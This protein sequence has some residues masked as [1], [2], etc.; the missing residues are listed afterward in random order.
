MEFQD[1][2]RVDRP[3]ASNLGEPCSNP[4]GSLPDFRM[5]E[6]CQTVLLA[7]AFSRGSPISPALHA[8]T[9]PYSPHFASI[10]SQDLNVKNRSNLSTTLNLYEPWRY[11]TLYEV[12]EELSV[13]GDDFTRRICHLYITFEEFLEQ[14]K[15][16]GRPDIHYD[17][18]N[19][20]NVQVTKRVEDS[21]GIVGKITRR[22]PRRVLGYSDSEDASNNLI[23]PAN[24]LGETRMKETLNDKIQISSTVLECSGTCHHKCR[25]KRGHR[26]AYNSSRSLRTVKCVSDF[27]ETGDTGYTEV[28]KELSTS[29]LNEMLPSRVNSDGEKDSTVCYAGTNSVDSGYKSSCP[30]PDLSE[31]I[32][33]EN[34]QTLVDRQAY[35]R[36]RI[37][38]GTKVINRPSQYADRNLEQLL[39]LRQSILIAM[40]RYE[41]QKSKSCPS[42]SF[43]PR[44]LSAST[45]GYQYGKQ[46]LKHQARPLI[47]SYPSSRTQS[48]SYNPR[49]LPTEN[50]LDLINYD[51]FA[52]PDSYTSTSDD[53]Y[54]YSSS[55]NLRMQQEPKISSGG[56]CDRTTEPWV[57]MQTPNTTRLSGHEV[58]QGYTLVD[59]DGSDVISERAGIR[60]ESIF[61][62]RDVA[63]AYELLNDTFVLVARIEMLLSLSTMLMMYQQPLFPIYTIYQKV[64]CFKGYYAVVRRQQCLP[65]GLARPG[66]PDLNPIEHLWDELD[67][68]VRARQARPK[69]IAQLMEWLQEEWK[70]DELQ[71]KRSSTLNTDEHTTTATNKNKFDIK[72]QKGGE[73]DHEESIDENKHEGS[74][75]TDDFDGDLLDALTRPSNT[76]AATSDVKTE[77]AE[78]TGYLTY[79]PKTRMNIL[80]E[81]LTERLKDCGADCG[82]H[83]GRDYGADCVEAIGIYNGN[84]GCWYIIIMIDNSNIISFL[85]HLHFN[86]YNKYECITQQLISSNIAMKTD[87]F[88]VPALSDMTTAEPPGSTSVSSTELSVVNWCLLLKGFASSPLHNANTPGLLLGDLNYCKQDGHTPASLA[89]NSITNMAAERERNQHP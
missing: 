55:A 63:T 28:M 60:N 35:A 23:P 10:I 14:Q 69:F 21:S 83:W 11:P 56:G 54:W 27:N 81:I 2:S 53:R 42:P 70:V 57:G 18:S 9:A 22:C 32:G 78:N 25:Y 7:G 66:P 37:L 44:S 64:S 39:Y 82:A 24:T 76:F 68:W 20:Y 12:S 62:E 38:M 29:D 36:S 33:H 34:K 8:G 67:R 88:L 4:G 30:T 16:A 87:S 74:E 13:Q 75:S 89:A 86:A 46:R 73:D 45:S 50:T 79:F 6:S 85:K 84:N 49:I 3:V 58:G 26:K 43:R 59:P 40:Q 19:H 80:M 71:N 17:G 15:L 77:D 72:Y 1:G 52:L 47:S 65:I 5:W 41:Q 61:I 48:P 31:I 51:N